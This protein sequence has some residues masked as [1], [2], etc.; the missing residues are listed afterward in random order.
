MQLKNKRLNFTC[1][2]LERDWSNWRMKTSIIWRQNMVFA[3]KWNNWINGIGKHHEFRAMDFGGVKQS[4]LMSFDGL[5]LQHHTNQTE[6][7]SCVLICTFPPSVDVYTFRNLREKWCK[8]ILHECAWFT[9]LDRG[10]QDG[11]ISIR[12]DIGYRSVGK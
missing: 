7:H 6:R 5:F 3:A 9:I 1:S 4:G 12:M 8:Y 11:F 2:E 10:I